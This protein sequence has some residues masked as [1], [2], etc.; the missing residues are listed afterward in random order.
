MTRRL[1]LL[2]AYDGTDFA[3]W[4]YQPGLRTVQGVLAAAL[5]R[6]N[7]DRPVAVRGAG[8]TDAGVH[9]LGQI[10]DCPFQGDLDDA[11]I[12]HA[13]TRMLPDDLRALA[14][15]TASPGFH[16][17][18][19]ATAKV[20]V[21]RVDRS[22]HGDPFL[23][24]YAAWRPGQLDRELVERALALLPGRRDWSGFT[25]ASCTIEDRVRTLT[26]ARYDEEAELGRFTFAADG[27]LTHMVRN[28]VGTLLEIGRG[29]FAP[30]Q[31][32][33][34]LVSGDR[35]LAG[36]TAPAA[37][38]FLERVVYDNAGLGGRA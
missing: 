13:L 9:A 18:H 7:G 5:T 15:A 3:G 32:E 19:H 8:R 10:A 33:R 14:V 1:R 34:V 17:R 24:R 26:E 6:L 21:Y 16:A 37:G 11:G 2:L 31:I 25:A 36:P 23:R 12:A 20:Y 30:D 4:Q 22:A 29:R 28:L 35:S 38:L 27:F